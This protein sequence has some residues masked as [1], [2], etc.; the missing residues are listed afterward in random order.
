M[1][2]HLLK[3]F[4]FFI[5]YIPWGDSTWHTCTLITAKHTSERGLQVALLIYSRCPLQ[6]Q[7]IATTRFEQDGKLHI[8]LPPIWIQHRVVRWK[9]LSVNCDDMFRMQKVVRW[10][11]LEA[12]I[13]V[14][15]GVS[16]LKNIF[17]FHRIYPSICS[18]TI[19]G[20]PMNPL[21]PGRQ[22]LH[23]WKQCWI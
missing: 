4:L 1:S 11:G 22:V 16:L 5:S 14:L 13:K 18:I 10:P 17:V 9:S 3:Y 2:F 23:L 21:G 6:P 12:S 8:Y 20:L 15:R 19:P 7:P